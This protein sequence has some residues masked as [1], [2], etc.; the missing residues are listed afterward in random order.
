M[1]KEEENEKIEKEFNS[2]HIRI[3]SKRDYIKIEIKNKKTLSQYESSFNL[4]NLRKYKLLVH[5]FSINEMIEFFIQMIDK[6]NILINENEN[7]LK[8][9]L[10]SQIYSNVKLILN[11]KINIGSL[12][13]ELQ[14]VK[15]E[16]KLLKVNNE[17]IKNIALTTK[18]NYDKLTKRIEF[19]EKEKDNLNKRIEFIEKEKDKLNKRIG[20]VEKNYEELKKRM[21]IL[22]LKIMKKKI[23]LLT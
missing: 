2:Y 10:I 21:K 4:E 1:S 17:F 5:N 12:I 7:T 23:K 20:L 13:K 16:N 19:I 8:F 9:I 6:K 18:E 11:K 14:N 15:E 3:I 22:K